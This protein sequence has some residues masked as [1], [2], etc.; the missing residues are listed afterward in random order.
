MPPLI[1]YSFVYHSY[2]HMRNSQSLHSL[3]AAESNVTLNFL[4]VLMAALFAACLYSSSA[5]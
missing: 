2:V 5:T 1:L 3:V 4:N